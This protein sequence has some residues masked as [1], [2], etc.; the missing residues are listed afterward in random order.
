MVPVIV[1]RLVTG[2][3]RSTVSP[4]RAPRRSSV[5][6]VTMSSLRVVG[7]E[8]SSTCQWPSSDGSQTLP[9]TAVSPTGPC[10]PWSTTGV[11]PTGIDRAPS[12]TWARTF[13]NG[14][15]SSDLVTGLFRFESVNSHCTGSCTMPG[16]SGP[17]TRI[18]ADA[19]PRS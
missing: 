12:G 10:A 9:S 8:P 19:R 13:V 16:R 7:V 14:E 4:I 18:C 3:V 11:L 15:S 6:G 1:K 2:S 17:D 5:A